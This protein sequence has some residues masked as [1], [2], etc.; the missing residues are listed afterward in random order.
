MEAGHLRPND[1]GLEETNVIQK[2]NFRLLKS[3]AIFG[4]NSSGKSNLTTAM[5]AF[6]FMVQRSVAE[7]GVPL[8]IWEDRFQLGEDDWDDEPVF[9]QYFFLH[10]NEVY[11]YGFQILKEKVTY[12]WLFK[13]VKEETEIFMRTPNGSISLDENLLPLSDP[14]VGHAVKGSSEVFREDSLFLTAGALT[15]NQLLAAVRNSIRSM[16]TADGAYDDAHD[17]ALRKLEKGSKRQREL[18]IELLIAADTGIED[19]AITDIGEHST[20]SSGSSEVQVK[21]NRQKKN[22]LL[23]IHSRY[24]SEG[25]L[26][27]KISVPF[28]HWESQGTSKIFALGS[29]I[30][31]ALQFGLTMVVDE[32]DSRLHPNLTLKITQ[33]FHSPVT[34]PKNAQFIFVTHDSNLLKKAKLRRDQI[35]F[36]N[37]NKFGI[38]RIS[39]LIEYKGVR[40]DASYDKEYLEGSYTGVPYL[41]KMDTVIKH[42]LK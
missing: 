28:L 19:L 14:F 18:I 35:C 41:D 15:G 7:E 2:G 39:N 42:A 24:N 1:S 4:S 33:L 36:V 29:L 37:K 10:E 34:N 8:R 16:I 17:F 22:K 11:R 23:S 5:S 9:F 3:K 32:F 6:I 25:K 31:D 20:G 27:D 12:E 21:E 26:I 13:G 40:K 38:S 30:L